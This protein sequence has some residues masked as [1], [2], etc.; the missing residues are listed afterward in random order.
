MIVQ[1]IGY[2]I[3]AKKIDTSIM[4]TVLLRYVHNY[5]FCNLPTQ[6]LTMAIQPTESTVI[7]IDV[8]ITFVDITNVL[9]CNY[10]RDFIEVMRAVNGTIS[11]AKHCT[12]KDI[13][14]VKEENRLISV[15][16]NQSHPVD[17]HDICEIIIEH[18]D[19][20]NELFKTIERDLVESEYGCDGCSKLVLERSRPFRVAFA[21]FGSAVKKI[22]TFYA[23]LIMDEQNNELILSHAK[24]YIE[25]CNVLIQSLETAVN[26][27]N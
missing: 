6:H 13:E 7:P 15:A 8:T 5:P 3:L 25:T 10:E 17:K 26:T 2:M 18:G 21:T 23:R 11:F 22:T 1:T 14:N 12:K 19:Y 24:A 20:I 16:F 9:Q 4:M 27:L